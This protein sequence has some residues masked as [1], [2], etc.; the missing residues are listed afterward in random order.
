[1]DEMQFLYDFRSEVPPADEET[2]RRIYAYA[3]TDRRPRFWKIDRSP[4]RIRAPRRRRL[5]LA[6]AAFA[7]AAAIA[8]AAVAAPGWLTGSPAPANVQSDFGSYSSQLGFNP[9]PG[10]AVLV[11]SNGDYQLYATVNRQGGICTLVSSPWNRP[12][13]NGDGGDCSANTPDSSAFW[14][15]IGGTASAPD[16]ATTVALYGHTTEASA[17]SVQFD[18]PSGDTLSAPVSASGFFII[19]TTL[20]GSL[21]DWSNWTSRFTVLDGGGQ[22]LSS[23][24]VVLFPGATKTSLPGGGQVC[25]ASTGTSAGG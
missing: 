24:S 5:V 18:T 9:Q 2:R 15:G 10:Q 4:S 6:T 21:C 8:G 25:T 16:H 22:Q 14:A 11:A 20:P 3:T 19:G 12:G 7:T 13:A 1:M 17:A 23:A